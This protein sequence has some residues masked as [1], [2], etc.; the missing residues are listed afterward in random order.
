MFKKKHTTVNVSEDYQNI[1]V[2]PFCKEKSP[3]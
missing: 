2:N 1:M 3:G